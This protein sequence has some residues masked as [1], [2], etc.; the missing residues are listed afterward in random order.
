MKCEHL[1]NAYLIKGKLWKEQMH[2]QDRSMKG[3]LS[4][5]DLRIL[6]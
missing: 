4:A 1:E 2:Q 3:K 5:L 6:E